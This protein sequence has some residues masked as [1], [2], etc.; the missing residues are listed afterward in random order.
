[1]KQQ[2]QEFDFEEYLFKKYPD[3]FSTDNSGNLLPQQVRCWNDCPKGW[4]SIVDSLFGCIDL[5]VKNTTRSKAN[6]KRK[7]VFACRRKSNYVI[8]YLLRLVS[9]RGSLYSLDSDPTW[10]S[11]T[12]K[13][14]NCLYMKLFN[15]SDL[16]ITEHPPAVKIQQYKEKF[17]TLRIYHNGGDDEVDGMIRYAEFLSS[18][19]C[20]DT[21]KP[22]KL[23][24]KG[25]WYVT[26]S[27][28]Q[29]KKNG[30]TA[31]ADV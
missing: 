21:G 16:Y 2:K 5:Y 24:K 9:P 30:F 20:E 23:H 14:L 19:T 15:P 10:R 12:M 6:P 13:V 7:I 1:M 11:K 27:D 28:A 8:Q 22:G 18:V 31:V 4:E 29:A 26:L 3:L 25:G 17:G